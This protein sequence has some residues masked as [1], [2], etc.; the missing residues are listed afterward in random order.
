VPLAFIGC[1]CNI[2]RASERD[3]R[4]MPS[5]SLNWARSGQQLT[6]NGAWQRWI[7]LP[8]GAQFRSRLNNPT[9]LSETFRSFVLSYVRQSRTPASP[10]AGSSRDLAEQRSTCFSFGSCGQLED[11]VPHARALSPANIQH[12]ACSK[13]SRPRQQTEFTLAIS[14]LATPSQSSSE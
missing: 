10:C 14:S 7:G 6:L 1:C 3:Q 5:T 13:G 9:S 11:G 8:E 4:A 2:V 12:Q